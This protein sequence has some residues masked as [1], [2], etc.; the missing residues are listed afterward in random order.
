[1]DPA[2]TSKAPE[3]EFARAWSNAGYESIPGEIWET[4]T[5]LR[6]RRHHYAHV[7]RVVGKKFADHISAVGN[8]LNAFWIESEQT[9]PLGSVDFTTSAVFSFSL[10]EVIAIQR[11]VLRWIEWV[12]RKVTSA[13]DPGKVLSPVASE[14][15]AS[16]GGKKFRKN[17]QTIQEL[18]RRFGVRLRE[19]WGWKPAPGVLVEALWNA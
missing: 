15:V 19:R 10:D 16:A 14:V 3:D 12:D 13:I 5:Y 18:A 6:L 7:A 8:R 4:C 2:A 17:D 11:I 1:L 9:V